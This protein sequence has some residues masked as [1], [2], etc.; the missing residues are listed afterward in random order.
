MH[1]GVVRTELTREMRSEGFGKFMYY[2]MNLLMYPL[3]WLMSKSAWNGCQTT[4][5][6]AL[7]EKVESGCYYADCRRDWENVEVTK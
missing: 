1:P 4:L 2:V 3:Y 6:C 5:H 7:S